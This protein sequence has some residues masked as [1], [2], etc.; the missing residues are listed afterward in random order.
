MSLRA[1]I[2]RFRRSSGDLIVDL[3]EAG[4]PLHGCPNVGLKQRTLA[5]YEA[6]SYSPTSSHQCFVCQ[7]HF[8]SR[9]RLAGA[10]LIAVPAA[11]PRPSSAAIGAVCDAC[12]GSKSL[13]EIEIAATSLLRR[14]CPDGRFTPLPNPRAMLPAPAC[15][16]FFERAETRQ[17]SRE[18]NAR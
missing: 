12:W 14:V 18:E 4:T 3:F 11:D 6:G 8:R 16:D 7:W 10:F 1:D 15:S 2:A 13:P 9:A 5:Y 17:A